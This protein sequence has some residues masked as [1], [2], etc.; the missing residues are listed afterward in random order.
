MSSDFPTFAEVGE[1]NVR[2]YM[3]RIGRRFQ[4]TTEM[5]RRYQEEDFDD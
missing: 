2:Q 4:P 5:L 3:T 1:E